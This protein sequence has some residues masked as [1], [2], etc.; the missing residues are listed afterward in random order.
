MSIVLLIRSLINPIRH[1]QTVLLNA[2]GRTAQA[3][4]HAPG[5]VAVHLETSENAA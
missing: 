2:G 1:Q 5:K 4:R 3:A